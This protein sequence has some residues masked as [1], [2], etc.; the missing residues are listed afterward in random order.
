[1]LSPIEIE[2]FENVC[3]RIAN[4]A[5]HENGFIAVKD[6]LGKFQATLSIRPLL[7]EGMIA[8]TN[9]TL[10]QSDAGTSWIVLI[11][12]DTSGIDEHDVQRENVEHPLPK[13][14][15][16]TIAH[17]LAHTLAFQ[18]RYLGIQLAVKSK[19]LSQH[20]LVT[21]I[22]RET[23]RLS[24]FLLVSEKGI[25]KYLANKQHAV[26]AHDVR[27]AMTSLG[28]SREVLISRLKSVKLA[29]A[30][31]LRLASGLRN[32]CIGIGQWTA[33]TG[34]VLKKWPLFVN[35]DKNIVPTFLIELHRRDNLPLN[36]IHDGWQL[37]AQT[38]NS[39]E[40][41]SDAGV[42]SSPK[43]TKMKVQLTLEKTSSKLGQ[44]FIFTASKVQD[45]DDHLD[46]DNL[47][48]Q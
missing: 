12:S 29:D 28:V 14:V 2:A 26:S 37:A 5:A 11:D 27:M 41:I 40:F 22:E 18:H 45:I 20:A 13:R 17:E 38:N 15:R 44:A 19:T 7:V 25:R 34:P 6:L 31:G 9:E 43:S 23:E 21:S 4:E 39:F 10:P 3:S 42:G 24:P 1:M 46:S 30:G 47:I 33:E 48:S 36:Q 35:F 32:L 8:T 16:N